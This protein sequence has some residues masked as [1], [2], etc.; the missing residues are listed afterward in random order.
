MPKDQLPFLFL[1]LQTQMKTDAMISIQLFVFNSF[2]VNTYLLFDETGECI[3]VDPAC[4]EERE[5]Q[6]LKDF[7]VRKNLTLV[8]NINTHCHIDHIL[9]NGY[10]A[11]TF[12]I[13][14]EYHK[15][16]VPFFYTAKEVAGSFGYDMN[17]I[18]EPKG[19]LDESEKVTFGKSEL[20]VFYTP[21][22][23]EGSVCFYNQPNGFVITGDVMFKDTIG[24]TDLP[25]G[26]FNLLMKSIREKLFTLPDETVV[27]P[28]HG[29]ETSIGYEKLNNPFIR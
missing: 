22:H 19:F 3:V 18:P 26:D 28:G 13:F 1:L 17:H 6:E 16:S 21:G 5:K 27:Y 7:L 25:S 10:I 24:R 12:R 2:M 20:A 23:A 9:G 4:Y 8:R 14:P 29:P 11:E 15:T